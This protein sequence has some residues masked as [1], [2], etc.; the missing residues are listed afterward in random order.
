MQA[1]AAA[2]AEAER[3]AS[4]YLAKAKKSLDDTKALQ[5]KH[6]EASTRLLDMMASQRR[7]QDVTNKI[8]KLI[9][10]EGVTPVATAKLQGMLVSH[11]RTAEA[12]KKLKDFMVEEG[13]AETETAM[14]LEDI[15][16]CQTKTTEANDKLEKMLE[17]EHMTLQEAEEILTVVVDTQERTT[18]KATQLQ[19]M[20]DSKTEV[21]NK[22]ITTLTDAV[23][24]RVVKLK[25]AQGVLQSLQSTMPTLTEEAEGVTE[26]DNKANVMQK[27]DATNNAVL[28]VNNN[29][30]F[31]YSLHSF[32]IHF[33]Y[34]FYDIKLKFYRR[35]I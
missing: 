10:E 13:L 19:E 15:I 12:A 22:K 1:S 16:E 25:E 24:A 28:Q 8:K 31:K 29:S 20:V 6:S 2:A 5:E 21:I 23:E 32:N 35:Y 33:L 4:E 17:T 18:D 11:Q 7:T 34:C 3:K 27:L 14:K 30:V 9:S 26:T